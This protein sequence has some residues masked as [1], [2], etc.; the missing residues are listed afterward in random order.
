MPLDSEFSCQNSNPD[1]FS[2]SV[3]RVGDGYIDVCI[4]S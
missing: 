2:A 1:V 4:N 3:E